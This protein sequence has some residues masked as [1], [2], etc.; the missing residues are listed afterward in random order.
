M[1]CKLVIQNLGSR[2]LESVRVS[3][4]DHAASAVQDQPLHVALVRNDVGALRP[5]NPEL[6]EELDEGAL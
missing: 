2:H 3:N 1:V 5:V 6:R 4:V